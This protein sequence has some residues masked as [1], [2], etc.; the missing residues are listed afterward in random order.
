MVVWY[1]ILLYKRNFN[2]LRGMSGGGRL[3]D[4]DKIIL[5]EIWVGVT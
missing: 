2:L 1:I 3:G 4:D 5:K